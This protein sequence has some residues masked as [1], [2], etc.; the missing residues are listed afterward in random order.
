MFLHALMVA[1]LAA[2]GGG[3]GAS[4][5]PTASAADSSGT[6]GT[7]TA[8]P[9]AAATLPSISSVVGTARVLSAAASLS[10]EGLPE[11]P[12]AA[13]ATT[14]AA[15][16]RTFYVDSSAGNDAND[17][18]AAGAGALN[19][20]PWRTLGRLMQS[21]I[22]A[23]DS[24]TLACNSSWRETLRLPASGTAASPIVVSAPASGC[25]M[26]PVIDGSISIAASAW[27]AYKGNIFQAPLDS[28]PMQLYASS[29]NF[30]VAH[31]PNRGYLTSDPTSPYAALAADGNVVSG[32]NGN[33]GSTVLQVGSDLALP[34]G[35]VIAPG[36]RIRVRTYAWLMEEGT[37]SAVDGNR[38]TLASPTSYPVAANRGYVLLGQ[39]W[40]LDSAGEWYYDA[41]A[42]K[43]YAW[44]PDSAAP[45][46]TVGASVL[47]TGIDLSSRSY[48][49]IDGLTVRKVGTGVLMRGTKGVVV[50]NSTIEDAAAMGADAAFSTAATFESNTITRAGQDAIS[51]QDD[52]TGAATGM[53]VSNNVIRDSGVVMQDET[54]LSV[55]IASHAAIRSG[56]AS[57]VSG[58]VIVNAGYIG[59]RPGASSV[60]QNNFV[61]GACTVLDDGGAIYTWFDHDIAIRGNTVIH[62]RGALAGKPASE[63]FTQ[64]QGIYLDEW[65]TAT[66]VEDNTVIDTDN[67]V[68]VHVSYNNTV[69]NNRLYG[70]RVSQL[71]MAETSNQ[72]RASGDVYGNVITGNQ[73]AAVY[74]TS[75]GLQLQSIYASTSAFG[76]FDTNHYYE[77][78]SPIVASV[79]AG[80]TQQTYSLPQ[81]RQSHNAGST[82]P[83]DG[84]GTG[85]NGR[86]YTSYSVAGA[87]LVPN[88]GLQQN[89]A[90][91]GSWNQTAPMA[92]MVQL[93]C[94][95]G[96]CLRFVA[97]GSTGLL[98][99]PSFAVQKGQWYRLTVDVAADTEGQ[100]VS[101]VA[102]RAGG[103]YAPYSDRAIA[104]TAGTAWGRYSVIFQSTDTLTPNAA[105]GDIGARVDIEGLLPG[106]SITM[107][108][109]EVVAIT[110][111]ATS[112]LSGALINAGTAPRSATCPLT[113]TQAAQCSK[114]LTLAD[115]QTVTW[116]LTIPAHSAVIIY[117]QDPSLR[118]SD[119]D[120]IPDSQDRCPGT[121]AGT[122]VNSAGCSFTQ[123]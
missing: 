122:Q 67:G 40:M 2:C 110:P 94:P 11:A 25:K 58:N 84:N 82:Q 106:K 26:P 85:V 62:A 43:I 18:R 46:A 87:N 108:N 6:G 35:A 65:T 50:R 45:S 54:V 116:P 1:G 20:G 89:L 56:I 59:I 113:G 8:A 117:A 10:V 103:S 75:V 81:W 83:V 114:F 121:V 31:H 49:T 97:G 23:G 52:N 19:S 15:G 77:R 44:M 95:A 33:S 78:A 16:G 86:G 115:S 5:T 60:V 91:W 100:W 37:V 102:R 29:G 112:Q 32:S 17:G 61:F 9:T 92:Q 3:G 30:T 79:S 41:N 28:A 69:R 98:A 109:L 34:T 90:G 38:L 12:A 63:N 68:V 80:G 57:T 123:R 24:V 48:V 55:P 96:Q 72:K 88:G 64:A 93:T 119:G 14:A 120:G 111:D 101:L 47:A 73:I 70:N 27:T 51:G 36:A 76:N 22:T 71:S 104:F 7:S 105:T 118:D 21:D 74:P 4:D 66:V 53:T 39:L 42:K 99:S 13:A 107:A